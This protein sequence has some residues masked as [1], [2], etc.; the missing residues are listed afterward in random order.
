MSKI[1]VV[2]HAGRADAIELA[3]ATMAQL[4]SEGHETWSPAGDQ[5]GATTF[6]SD[7][8]ASEA[9]LIVCLGGDGTMLKAV[10]LLDGAPVPLLGVN[11]GRLGYLTEIEADKLERALTRF[12]LGPDKGQW[13]LDER[14][15]VD[16]EIT[17]RESASG[18]RYRALNEVVAEKLVTGHTVHLLARIDG[19]P[20]TTYA[21]DGLIVATPTGSTAYSLSAR[22][23][24]VSPKHRALL[25]TPVAPHMLFDRTLVLDPEESV[26]IEVI[27]NRPAAVGI[28]GRQV[29]TLDVGDSIRCWRSDATAR[30][31]RFATH[32]YHQVLKAKFGLREVLPRP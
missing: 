27:G 3:M 13:H 29:A 32:R 17:T 2:T 9:D 23:P 21:A 24:V 20:F 8:P 26:E 12:E 5:I 28:D 30:F 19:E 25:L 7:R 10:H 16:I 22:G 15:M 18:L 1:M 4:H 6:S 14:M 31:M 11:K